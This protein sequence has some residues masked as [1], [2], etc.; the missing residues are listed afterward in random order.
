MAVFAKRAREIKMEIEPI[1]L[2]FESTFTSGTF[3]N[4]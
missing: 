1:H 4:C 3:P 2:N